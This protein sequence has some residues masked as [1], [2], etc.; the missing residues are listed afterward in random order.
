MADAEF[1]WRHFAAELIL[2]CVRWHCRYGISYRDLDHLV[3]T[4]WLGPEPSLYGVHCVKRI[5]LLRL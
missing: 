3:S 2:V 4:R 5:L 1:K